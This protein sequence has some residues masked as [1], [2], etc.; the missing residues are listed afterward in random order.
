MSEMRL[1]R[2]PK[3]LLTQREKFEMRLNR[4]AGI[5]VEDCAKLAGVSRSTCL[6]YLAELR[7]L[8]GPEKLK[9]ERRARS[10]LGRPEFRGHEKQTS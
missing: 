8:F 4:E 9:N 2:G 3:E 10:F 6:K 7:Q 1:K 5:P